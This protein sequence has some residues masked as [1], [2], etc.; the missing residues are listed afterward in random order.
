MYSPG[1]LI[2]FDPFLFKNGD[3]KRKYFLVLKVTDS[4]VVVA[5]LPSSVDHLPANQ[6]IVHGCLEIL[7]SGINC[8]IFE[9]NQAVTK[10]GWSFEL[11]T[12]LYGWWIDDFDIEL[13]NEQYQIEHVDY[14]IVGELTDEELQKV[15]HCFANSSVVR[16]KYKRLLGGA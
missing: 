2:Y 8:Y 9:A 15:I 1:K 7:D 12:F 4:N 14:E 13:L 16:R 10:D 5:S 3:S 11:T 6:P